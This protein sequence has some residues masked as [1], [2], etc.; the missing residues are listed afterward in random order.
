MYPPRD[1]RLGRTAEH[2]CET[3]SFNMYGT[4]LQK[5]RWLETPFQYIK[6]VRASQ[7]LTGQD[8]ILTLHNCCNYDTLPV[9]SKPE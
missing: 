8:P 3:T 7:T 1:D 5:S 6:R 2:R 9:R 4:S